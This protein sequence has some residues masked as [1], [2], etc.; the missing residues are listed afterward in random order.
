MKRKRSKFGNKWTRVDGIKFQSKAEAA[1]YKFLKKLEEKGVIFDLKWQVTFD[2][3]AKIRYRAD[4]TYLEG[5][6]PELVVE[7]VKG[8]ETDVFRLKEKLFRHFH[9]HLRFRIVKLWRNTDWVIV[10]E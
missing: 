5:G 2:L 6:D 7:D 1:R 3:V 10:R 8:Q 9:P 4:F